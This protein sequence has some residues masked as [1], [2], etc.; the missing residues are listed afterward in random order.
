[1][2]MHAARPVATATACLF[3]W[4][5]LCGVAPAADRGGDC[6]DLDA[7]VFPGQTEVVGNRYDDDCDG[8]ADEAANGDPSSDA[9]DLDSDGQSLQ[10]GDCDDT[11]G[12]V[13]S[14]NA[15]VPD[16][17]IDDD[18]DGLADEDA[19]NLPSTDDFDADGDG[20]GL[21]DRVFRSGFEAVVL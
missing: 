1:M 14:G 16:N 9:G 20:F 13:R 8:L 4:L 19:D 11:N 18:C 6:N 21:F 2:S 12:G 10:S 3:A 7:A 15:E 17:A 5:A